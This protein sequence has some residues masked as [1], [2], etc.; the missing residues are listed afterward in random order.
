MEGK[1]EHFDL[2]SVFTV[3]LFLKETVNFQMRKKLL[4]TNNDIHEG[5]RYY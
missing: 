3:A 5:K 4:L 1:H 2:S